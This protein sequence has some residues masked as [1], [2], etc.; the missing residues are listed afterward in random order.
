VKIVDNFL[1]EESYNKLKRMIVF[2][3][4][5]PLY[6]RDYVGE[7]S[8]SEAEE[9]SRDQFH[10]YFFTHTVFFED[11]PVSPLYDEVK[12]FFENKLEIETL[13]R[14]RVNLY[15]NANEVKEHG[16]HIDYNFSHTAAIY[17]LNTCDGFTRIGED[18]VDS[19][20]NRIYFFDGGELHNSSNTSNAMARFNLVFNYI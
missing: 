1:P 13:L 8:Y 2:N 17:C 11:E 19:V 5:L 3:P 10:N 15:P 12:K 16:Q 9:N 14:I 20:A 7:D 6:A 18:K 4:N